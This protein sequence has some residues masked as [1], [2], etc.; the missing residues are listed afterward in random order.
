MHDIGGWNRPGRAAATM[1]AVGDVLRE[2]LAG[3]VS[4]DSIAGLQEVV[5]FRILLK[6]KRT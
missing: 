4:M 3:S 5:E 2:D 6:V 1:A